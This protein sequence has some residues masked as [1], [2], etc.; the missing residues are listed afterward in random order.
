MSASMEKMLFCVSCGISISGVNATSF[1]CPN[2][3]TIISRCAKCKKQ[4]NRYQCPDCNFEG[5]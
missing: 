5:P 4:S 2:G 3:D 1:E